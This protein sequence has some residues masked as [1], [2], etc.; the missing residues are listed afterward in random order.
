MTISLY[1]KAFNISI[2]PHTTE[3]RYLKPYLIPIV[4][5]VKSGQKGDRARRAKD[6]HEVLVD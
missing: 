1:S 3:C 2:F 5:V 6:S 4:H